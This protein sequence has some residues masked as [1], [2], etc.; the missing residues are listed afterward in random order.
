MND[1]KTN[2]DI[3]T[4]DYVVTN[5]LKNITGRAVMY[6][7][8]GFPVHLRGPAGVGKTS[9]AIHI[10]KKRGRPLLLICGGEEVNNE[11]LIGGYFG[12]RKYSVEDNFITTVHKKEELIRKTWNDGRL[13]TA[14][15][16]GYTVIYDEFTRTPAVIN[17]V[18]LSILEE[19]LVDIPYG[20]SNTFVKIHPEFRI[21]FTSNPDEYIGVYRSPN[22]LTDRMITIDMVDMDEDTEKSIIMSK[23]GLNSEESYKIMKLSRFIKSKLNDNDYASI[24]GGIMLAKIVHSSKLK[25]QPSN[26]A[27]RQVCKDIF[28]SIHISLSLSLDKKHELDYIVDQAIDSILMNNIVS[29]KESQ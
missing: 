14:C 28:N 10:A 29:V 24:R 13:L 18:L 15:K 17:N 19:K 20:N 1:V 2:F 8:N 6:M 25:M 5:Y 27:F 11:N 7:E 16:E 21:I 23:S 4:T 3:E 22:A 12:V 9:L 26:L